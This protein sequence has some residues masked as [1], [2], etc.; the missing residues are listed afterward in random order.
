MWD[1]AKVIE[2]S[3]W[4]QEAGLGETSSGKFLKS[5]AETG[6]PPFGRGAGWLDDLIRQGDPRPYSALGSELEK[7]I[8]TAGAD[9]DTLVRMVANLK[10]GY[11]PKDW[12]RD[13][14]ARL[15][16]KSRSGTTRLPTPGDV[17]LARDI[18]VYKS[19]QSMHYW[20]RK[21][22]TSNKIDKITHTILNNGAIYQEDVDYL[23]NNF[24]SL[25]KVI[26]RSDLDGKLSWVKISNIMSEE[27]RFRIPGPPEDTI[28]VILMG[29]PF[30]DPSFRRPVIKGLAD[31]KPVLVL[32]SDTAM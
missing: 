12:Y 28:P 29:Q 14:I 5:L 19:G 32:C 24:K 3:S 16:Q 1:H 2:M 26:T 13:F 21:P 30:V 31:G 8:P 17:K 11:P 20:S 25:V 23:L 6:R 18:S 7:L 4:W 9:A 27:T 15:Q 10:A 22:G